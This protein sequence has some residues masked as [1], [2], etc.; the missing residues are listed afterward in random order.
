MQWY[1]NW[2]LD[3]TYVRNGLGHLF[4]AQ[5]EFYCVQPELRGVTDA[6]DAADGKRQGFEQ[7]PLPILT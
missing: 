1:A 3:D 5:G 6:G 2:I 7:W 4:H